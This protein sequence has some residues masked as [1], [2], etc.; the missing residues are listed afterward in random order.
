MNREGGASSSRGAHVDAAFQLANQSMHDAQTEPR[1]I[2]AFGRLFGF[3]QAVEDRPRQSRSR[4]PH[5]DLYAFVSFAKN[6]GA[7][8]NR[9][10]L[11]LASLDGVADQVVEYLHKTLIIRGNCQ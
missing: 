3:S 9:H 2:P 11:P 10:A 5:R 1:M 6:T 7:A 4:I 8:G